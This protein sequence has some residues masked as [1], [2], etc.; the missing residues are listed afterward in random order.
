M[1][2][3]KPAL[4]VTRSKELVEV[5]L[6][7]FLTLLM[8]LN[9]GEVGSMEYKTEDSTFVVHVIGKDG[10]VNPTLHEAVLQCATEA[11]NF[12]QHTKAGVTHKYTL[13]LITPN[14]H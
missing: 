8:T 14:S 9:S 6:L 4:P 2:A 3:A 5:S 11:T 12:H 13:G 10:T 1:L 7:R